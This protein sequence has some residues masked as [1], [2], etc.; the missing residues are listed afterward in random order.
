[1]KIGCSTLWLL[2]HPLD[3]AVEQLVGLGFDHVEIGF[4][5]GET[6]PY[7]VDRATFRR[8]E[9]IIARSA[10]SLSVHAPWGRIY[11]LTGEAW[12]EAMVHFR[13]C[14]EFARDL[15]ADFTVFHY[16]EERSDRLSELFRVARE[17]DNAVAIEDYDVGYPVVWDVGHAHLRGALEQELETIGWRACEVHLH[18]N[19]GRTDDHF[20]LLRGE[21]DIPALLARML[22][23]RFDGILTLEFEEVASAREVEESMD[24]VRRVLSG[25]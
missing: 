10:V 5:P 7:P 12:G 17:H 24:L 13:R 11:E 23:R 8:L 3:V 16:R 18:N 19:F 6:T 25:G 22:R 4:Q 20:P 9:D 2:R 21:I 1:M 15:E 14:F